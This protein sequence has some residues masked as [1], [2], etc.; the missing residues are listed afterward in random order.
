[1]NSTINDVKIPSSANVSG[2]DQKPGQSTATDTQA[3]N[4]SKLS[5][6]KTT[7]QVPPPASDVIQSRE[8]AETALD[9]L[10]TLL[11]SQPSEALA[12]YS[13]ISGQTVAGVLD[14]AVSEA[15]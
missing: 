13:K 6:N 9:R 15:T 4:S 2:R 8:A 5:D 10:K 3:V 11:A 1:M 14:S 12:A 7:E